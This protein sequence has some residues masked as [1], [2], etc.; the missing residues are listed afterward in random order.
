MA[1][2]ITSSNSKDV[3]NKGKTNLPTVESE[4][5]SSTNSLKDLSPV[6]ENLD[7]KT[8]TN[9]EDDIA[10]IESRS[11]SAE[12]PRILRHLSG[13]HLSGQNDSLASLLPPQT[14]R[15]VY[16]RNGLLKHA[17]LFFLFLN[18]SSSNN[19]RSLSFYTEDRKHIG[20]HKYRKRANYKNNSSNNLY[21]W[22]ATM[23]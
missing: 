15:Q 10:Q 22:K 11:H 13:R 16:S 14:R 5:S 8:V 20:Q 2:S 18:I 21:S 4:S 19:D 12:P 7:L 17:K 3:P 1:S 23:V 9:L 6:M